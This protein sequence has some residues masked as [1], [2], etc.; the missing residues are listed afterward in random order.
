[1][2]PEEVVDSA[3][4]FGVRGASLESPMQIRHA[5]TEQ[6]DSEVKSSHRSRRHV[7][8]PREASWRVES[9]LQSKKPCPLWPVLKT[10]TNFVPSGKAPESLDTGKLYC[11]SA[12]SLL[13]AAMLKLATTTTTFWILMKFRSFESQFWGT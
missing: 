5:V 11:P 9:A 8:Q 4:A 12:G 2:C 3:S 10:P 7:I 6:I 13:T 1:M